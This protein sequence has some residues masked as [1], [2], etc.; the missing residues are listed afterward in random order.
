MTGM[1]F[2]KWPGLAINVLHE[3]PENGK[4]KTQK[5]DNPAAKGRQV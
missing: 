1:A 2:I 4:I 5:K 3:G